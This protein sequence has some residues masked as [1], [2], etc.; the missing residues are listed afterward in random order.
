MNQIASI[1]LTI[2]LFFGLSAKAAVKPSNYLCT[3]VFSSNVV[4]V[5][6]PD[7][8]E[9]TALFDQVQSSVDGYTS[10]TSFWRQQDAFID[11]AKNLHDVFSSNNEFK[12]SIQKNN[13]IR[14][15][16]PFCSIGY[17]VY[18]FGMVLLDFID[19]HGP[20]YGLNANTVVEIVGL[21][22]NGDAIAAAQKGL[23]PASPK[24]NA[25][26]GIYPPQSVVRLEPLK[27]RPKESNH[28]YLR[29]LN[30]KFL[31][32]AGN[33][34][35]GFDLFY[36]ITDPRLQV[37]FIEGLFNKSESRYPELFKRA[38]HFISARN[39]FGNNGQNE[40]MT[41]QESL[42]HWIGKF[43]IIINQFSN[44]IVDHAGFPWDKAKSSYSD[45]S[46]NEIHTFFDKK[47]GIETRYYVNPKKK[48]Y[49]IETV[50]FMSDKVLSKRSGRFSDFH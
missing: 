21:D 4:T 20:R 44:D 18:N 42:S 29:W 10:H 41:S 5:S 32:P 46:G 9:A 35:Y 3:R 14:M 12:K 36:K 47:T 49:K 24:N 22:F 28:L 11:F 1:V 2:G 33:P 37:H 43:G 27:S 19:V 7:L 48:T 23:I 8:Q 16:V 26:D 31:K 38:F 17:E 39:R 15:Y 34:E 40:I 45:E 30:Q 6:T 13:K 50:D 25:Q